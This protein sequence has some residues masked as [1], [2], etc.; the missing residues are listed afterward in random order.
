MR[1][2]D[3][4]LRS[5]MKAPVRKAVAL[6]L[7]AC[8]VAGNPTAWASKAKPNIYEA[9][10]E[11]QGQKTPEVST[12]EFRAIL[13]KAGTIVFDA[14]PPQEFEIAHIPGSINLDEKQLGRVT[15]NFPDQTTSMVVYSNGPCCDWARRGSEGLVRVGY[16]RGGR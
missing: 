15:Q 16:S 5:C 8:L 4:T 3:A 6:A 1:N 7:V 11:E 12:D 13:A 14:R 10:L 9:T 2:A